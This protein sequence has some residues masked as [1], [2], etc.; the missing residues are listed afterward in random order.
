MNSTR[1]S[2]V[3]LVESH[4]E[5][6]LAGLLVP[7]GLAVLLT[8]LW[9]ARFNPI[10][11]FTPST[12]DGLYLYIG[13]QLLKGAAPY[14]DVFDNKSPLLYLVSALGLAL[15]AGSFWGAYVLEYCLLVAS[16]VLTYLVLR[17]RVGWLVAGLAALFFVLEVGHITGG[18]HEEEYAVVL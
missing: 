11:H 3:T 17:A 8:I 6:R 15:G 5:S 14:R 4:A 10:T 9:F 12:D 16:T 2:G 13:Q 18:D 7:L 1:V